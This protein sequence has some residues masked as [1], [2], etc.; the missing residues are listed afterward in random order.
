MERGNPRQRGYEK[1][2]LSSGQRG[3]KG[4]L[5]AEERDPE[6]SETLSKEWNYESRTHR[7][8]TNRQ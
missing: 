2:Q 1:E 6:P 5:A 8:G 4:A 7:E 3:D